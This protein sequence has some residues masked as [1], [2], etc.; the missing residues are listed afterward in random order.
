MLS[1]RVHVA[2]MCT[3]GAMRSYGGACLRVGAKL[4]A[5][6]VDDIEGAVAAAARAEVALHIVWNA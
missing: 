3:C 1:Y 4:T 6:K 5:E 2:C